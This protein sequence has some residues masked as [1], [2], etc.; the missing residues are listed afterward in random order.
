[1][2]RALLLALSLAFAAAVAPAFALEPERRE[3]VVISERVW[4]GYDYTEAFVPS[5]DKRFS[6]IAGAPSAVT[7]VGT[8]EYYWPLSRRVYVDFEARREV[9]EGTLRIAQGDREVA[10]VPLEPF[11]VVYPQGAVNG[12]ATLVFG[13]EAEAAYAEHEAAQRE[14]VR[15]FAAARKAQTDYE[16]ALVEA[17]RARIVGD[18]PVAVPDPPQMP[19]PSLRLVTRPQM[20]HRVDLPP[21]DYSLA[22]WRDG[23][24]VEGTRRTLHVVAIDAREAIVADVVPEER[25]TRPIP[26]NS[27]AARLYARPGTT[28]YVTLAEAQHFDEA[29]YRAVVSPQASA[30][31]GRPL[32]VRRKAADVAALE[33]DW[34]AGPETAV[35]LADF[36]VSQTRGTGFGYVVR[37][38]GK[39][40]RVD[41]TAFAIKVPAAPDISHGT[42]AG[43]AG[44]GFEREVVIVHPRNEARGLILAALPLLAGAGLWLRRA[45]RERRETT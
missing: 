42:I 18:P 37:P 21:G 4:D 34:E 31:A 19:E 43:P 5:A 15:A 25:W 16:R 32:W 33:V 29:E 27:P 44:A 35:A 30:L 22:L 26:S 7:F 9:I 11:A 45:R 38:A 8:D 41:L 1:M 20:G 13:A 24:T 39:G 23:K 2:R 14:F 28:F 6:L 40:D 3:V 17:G 36:E 12:N 10:A